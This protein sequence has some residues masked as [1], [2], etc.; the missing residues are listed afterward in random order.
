MFNS[1]LEVES[2]QRDDQTWIFAIKGSLFGSTDA[3][4]FQDQVRSRISDGAKKIVVDLSSVD[5]LDSSGVGILVAVM[6]SASQ[7]G[8]G[9]VLASLPDRVEKVLEIA[10]LLDHIDHADSV[11][12]ALSR[13][14]GMDL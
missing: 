12:A 8:G 4:A 9:M 7:A 1:H 2:T 13:L 14:D 11:D 10:M 3:Y 5:R 6:W